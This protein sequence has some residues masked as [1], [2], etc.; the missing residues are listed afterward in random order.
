MQDPKTDFHS[1][2][3]AIIG[4]P[5]VGKSTLL[6]RILGQKIAITSDKPQTTRNRILGIHHLPDCQMLFL[7][8]PGIH[9]ARGK[10]NH[11]MVAQAL[12]ACG[13]VDL[14]LLL[15]EALPVA[16]P[17][18][19]MILEHLNRIKAPVF[20]VINKID[21]VAP[22][23]LLP[24][25]QAFSQKFTFAEIVPVSGL[26]GDGVDELLAA[27]RRRLPPGPPYFPEDM[28][29]DLP[30]RFIVSEMIREQLL[31][32][33]RDEIPYG[34]AVVVESFTEKADK[35]LVIIQAAIN[36]DRDSHKRIVVG[37]GGAMIRSLGRSAREEIERF[38]GCRVYLELFV[39]VQKGWT[40]SDRLLKEFG[41]H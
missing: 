16:G 25:I 12:G 18:E 17:E 30:E 15:V 20:L 1:G 10:L 41:Y 8:T 3:V 27:I 32:K 24:R 21:T 7:D 11:Y 22:A 37:K 38:L 26:T 13:D 35:N 28:V 9:S 2:F 36:V 34:V 6:N 4:R 23:A 39:R 31:R 19:A 14:V 40:E 5:N 33:T 29:T